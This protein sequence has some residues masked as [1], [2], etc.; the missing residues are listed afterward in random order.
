MP[1]IVKLTGIPA[2]KSGTENITIENAG[3]R[4]VSELE[5]ELRKKIPALSRYLLKFSVNGKLQ[6][7]DYLIKEEDHLLVFSAYSGG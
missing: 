5:L 3:I 4:S 7:E 1:F 2:E 6:S